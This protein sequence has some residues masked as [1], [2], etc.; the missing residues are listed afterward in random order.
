MM[1]E[2]IAWNKKMSFIVNFLEYIL[3]D[4]YRYRFLQNKWAVFIYQYEYIVYK[5]LALQGSKIKT[6]TR[7]HTKTRL[8]F[9]KRDFQNVYM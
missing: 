5:F 4:R 1:L 6:H 7:A 8:I 9:R 3:F 2:L